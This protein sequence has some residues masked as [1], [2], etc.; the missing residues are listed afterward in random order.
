MK[1]ITTRGQL[2]KGN[3]PGEGRLWESGEPMNK[4]R[5]RK[6]DLHLIEVATGPYKYPTREGDLVAC[7][8]S[9]LGCLIGIEMA[10]PPEVATVASI[11]RDDARS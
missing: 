7:W 8:G 11:T 3:R 6:V 4:K 2:R 1:E 9:W 10:F 5:R